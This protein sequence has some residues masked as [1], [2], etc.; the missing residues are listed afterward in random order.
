[1]VVVGL[2]MLPA[3][4]GAATK[5]LQ[6]KIPG[7]IK[8][9]GNKIEVENETGRDV[10]LLP[11]KFLHHEGLDGYR[12]LSDSG[13]LKVV[14]YDD[15]TP[16]EPAYRHGSLFPENAPDIVRRL[17]GPPAKLNS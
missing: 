12:V 17:G 9:D 2:K 5:F 1:M 16:E 13:T 4:A 3:E 8:V 6:S 15:S 7:G 14:P 11:H 10:K